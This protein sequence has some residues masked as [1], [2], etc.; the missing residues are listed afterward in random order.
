MFSRHVSTDSAVLDYIKISSVVDSLN[1]EWYLKAKLSSTVEQCSMKRQ[2][3][4][5]LQITVAW[6]ESSVGSGR[7]LFPPVRDHRFTGLPSADIAAFHLSEEGQLL[8]G[9]SRFGGSVQAEHGMEK[10]WS[11]MV[12]RSLGDTTVVLEHDSRYTLLMADNKSIFLYPH[13]LILWK[14]AL[15]RGQQQNSSSYPWKF[16]KHSFES[17]SLIGQG[18]RPLENPALEAVDALPHSSHNT[19]FL[20]MKPWLQKCTMQSIKRPYNF[21]VQLVSKLYMSSQACCVQGFLIHLQSN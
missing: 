9:S 18:S 10:Q 11:V 15:I 7:W 5:Q 3:S 13:P 2:S 1:S 16:A 21:W 8:L 19:V 14:N 6:K 17:E 4:I 12:L 20:I